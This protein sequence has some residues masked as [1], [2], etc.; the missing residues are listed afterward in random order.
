MFL[1]HIFP[2]MSLFFESPNP[3]NPRP[4][5][6]GDCGSLPPSS[7][8]AGFRNHPPYQQERFIPKIFVVNRLICI[9]YYN[10]KKLRFGISLVQK[11]WVFFFSQIWYPQFQWM[12]IFPIQIAGRCTP[13]FSTDIGWP[14][15]VPRRQLAAAPPPKASSQRSMPRL[16]HERPVLLEDH[17][18]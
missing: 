15:V 14:S 16:V 5:S 9:R 10:P 11:Y 18:I 7:T 2:K 12:I 8:G 13:H 1:S 3:P 17:R 4:Q 6:G